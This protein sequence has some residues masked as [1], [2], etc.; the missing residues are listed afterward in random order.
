MRE[1]SQ[2]LIHV[3]KFTPEEDEKGK[4]LPVGFESTEEVLEM[5]EWT[6]STSTVR[7]EDSKRC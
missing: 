5:T 3:V 6:R 7:R 2:I 1:D 4:R